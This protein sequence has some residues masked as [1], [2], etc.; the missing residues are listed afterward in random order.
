MKQKKD[1]DYIFLSTRV[2]AMERGLLT[3]ERIEQMLDAHTNEDAAKVLVECGYSEMAEVTD[4]ELDR[5]LREQ[6]QKMMADL[7]SS[8]PN[9]YVVD[10]FKLRYD[11]HNAKVLVK[12]EALGSEQDQLLMDGGRYDR[13]RLADDYRREDML[14][15]SDLFRR[16]V[17]RAR[18]VLG[19]TGDPQQADFIL[20]RAYFEELSALAKASESPFLEG[21][22][23]LCIDVANLRS[24]VRALRLNKSADFLNQVLVHGGT[25]SVHSLANA[26]GE[27]LGTLFHTSRLAD[28]A[29]EGGAKSAP[30][31]GPLTEFERMC[32]DAVM[33]YLSDG[34]RIPFG[35]EPIVGYLYARETEATIIRIIMA[36]R[37]AGLDRATIRQRLRRTYA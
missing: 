36:G 1:N 20:D 6:Q 33:D 27:E 18:E 3:K 22:S 24:V 8:A 14:A 10:V 12:T 35:A 37:M 25:V 17:A 4:S 2:K 32:D 34:R 19:S 29:A 15:Y 31:S 28:A 21:Y 13:Q 7:G 5:V 30:G 16:A 11:Y 9:K 26:R 23:A